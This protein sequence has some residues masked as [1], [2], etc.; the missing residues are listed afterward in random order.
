MSIWSKLIGMKKTEDKSNRVGNATASAQCS[1]HNYAVVDVEVCLKDHK[2]HDI[3]AHKHDDTIFHKTSKEE[4]FRFLDDIDYICGHNIIHHDAKYLFTDKTCR[5]ILVD[6][7][8]L[9]HISDPT[10]RP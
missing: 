6:T 4:L 9:I 7:L 5:W 1:A 2:I 8:S 10:R 3:G